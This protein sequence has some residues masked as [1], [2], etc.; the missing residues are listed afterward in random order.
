MV[1]SNSKGDRA[2]RTL[3]NALDARD[4]AVM[5]APASGSATERELPDVF[6]GKR[7]SSNTHFYAIELKRSSSDTIYIDE[8]EIEALEYFAEHFGATPLIGFKFDIERDDPAW[9]VDDDPGIYFMLPDRAYRT[10]GGNYRVKKEDI[11]EPTTS[12]I[13]GL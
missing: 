11:H 10:D 3:V 1:N 6:A 4:F 7:R 8:A 2:E 9:G 5:R 13:D 12:N